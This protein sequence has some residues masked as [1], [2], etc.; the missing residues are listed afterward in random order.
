M[1]PLVKEETEG[2]ENGISLDT[3]SFSKYSSKKPWRF[4]DHGYS[5]GQ[6]K[7]HICILCVFVPLW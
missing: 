5:H 6:R 3:S 7:R 1:K 2:E 4:F